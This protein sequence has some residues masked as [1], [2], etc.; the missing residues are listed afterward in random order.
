MIASMFAALF[1]ICF[2]L[3][4]PNL[5]FAGITSSYQ[6]T[7]Y[8]E[9]KAITSDGKFERFTLTGSAHN[10]ESQCNKQCGCSKTN[11]EPVSLK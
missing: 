2:F 3:S 11:Y 9:S 6:L 4:C 8:A 10:L 5:S 7:A 1:T